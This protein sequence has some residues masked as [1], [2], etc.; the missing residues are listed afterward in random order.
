MP[1]MPQ[2]KIDQALQV[3]RGHHKAG[4]LQQA[5][6][7]CRDILSFQPDQADALYLLGLIAARLGRHDQAI[8]CYRRVI[9]LLPHHLD[10]HTNLGVALCQVGQIEQAI[11]CFQQATALRPDRADAHY[12]L[13]K[14]LDI[15]GK[16]DQAVVCYQRALALNPKYVEA[17]L[18]LA[19]IWQ[20]T[21]EYS[22]AVASLQRALAIKP[23][24][25]DAH[26]NLGKALKDF[27]RL[28]EAIAS[29]E[30]ALTHNPGFA[31]ARFNLANV[32]KETG[33]LDQG[34]ACCQKG[35]A[36]N[37]R[38]AVGHET[39]LSIMRYHPAY[40]APKLYAAV[41]DWATQHA[42]PLQQVIARH[43]NNRDP[44]RRLRIGYVSADFYDHASALFFLPLFRHHDQQQVELFCYSQ[45]IQSDHVTREVQELVHGWR[46]T[47]GISDAEVASMVREDQIDILVDLKVHTADN[48]LLVFVRKPA[49]VQ[50]TWLGYPG[51]TGLDAVDYRL[52][53]PYL[54]PPGLDDAFYSER[55]V[56]LP[57]TF[58]CYD[59]L[60]DEPAINA[61]P[62][63]RN[64]F[65]TFG[66]LNNF[67]K[68]TDEVLGLWARVLTAV[69]G[70]RLMLLVPEGNSRSRV[71][72]RLGRDHIGPERIDFMDRVTRPEY[73]KAYHEIDIALDTFPCNGHT[74]SFDSSW[75]GVPVITLVGDR[76]FGRAG[77][78][79]LTNLRLSEL[80]A[81]S[82]QEYVRIAAGLAA[83]RPRL[84][85]LRATLRQR[86]Q[87]SPLMDGARFTR[88]VEAAYRTMW[89][90]WCAT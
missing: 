85:E 88:A 55:S 27:G 40:D 76:V 84:G 28:D 37:P 50:V 80:I 90:T 1:S 83:D 38:H 61:P 56:R 11:A 17:H 48:R 24:Y 54:D 53:D 43:T 22:A 30:K 19:N 10:A 72:A 66:C 77:F 44:E 49:P 36:I 18:N 74:T 13:G 65:I 25:A 73:L 23:D 31:Q 62:F 46:T 45:G 34:I 4:R 35:L 15:A 58:W 33:Q 42:Q 9:A 52:T 47:A 64:G 7:A 89:R 79:Q 21:G 2:A 68:V 59:P 81:R 70:S 86:M 51:T 8:D 60:C 14:A 5:E 29:Y 26:Y 12:N 87:V 69:P 32:Y 3:A 41:R 75:M 67:C 82:P 63:L 16:L 78:S 71:L 20:S 57:D 39:L 6:A